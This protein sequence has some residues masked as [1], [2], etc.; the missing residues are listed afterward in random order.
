MGKTGCEG[1]FSSSKGSDKDKKS[2]GIL[3]FPPSVCQ[4]EPGFDHYCGL[5]QLRL[6]LILQTLA[7]SLSALPHCLRMTSCGDSHET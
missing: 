2:V 7:L 1:F 6:M 3:V 5:L 4:Y